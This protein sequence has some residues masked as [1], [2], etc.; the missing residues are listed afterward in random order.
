MPPS[1]PMPPHAP[2]P[3]E[4]ASQVADLG[5]H[6]GT[7]SMFLL[8]LSPASERLPL[9][10]PVHKIWRWRFL[11]RHKFPYK[12]IEI[13][14]DLENMTLLKEYSKPPVTGPAQNG[15]IE[16]A[17]QIIQN[18]VLKMLRVTREHR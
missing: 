6:A 5:S 8:P 17:Q 4:L 12:V 2:A 13:T 10:K 16:I 9:P 1:K 11:Q 18:N 3:L 14:E 15:N 7:T